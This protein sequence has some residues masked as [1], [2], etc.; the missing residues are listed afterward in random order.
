MFA[1][2]K[3][4]EQFLLKLLA[5]AW[6]VPLTALQIKEKT[7]A[8]G[9]IHLIDVDHFLQSLVSHKHRPVKF[10]EAQKA[11]SI[12]HDLFAEYIRRHEC[13]E[14][15]I[16]LA[17]LQRLIDSAPQ[18]YKMTATLLTARQLAKLW[19]YRETLRLEP[20]VVEVI[21]TSELEESAGD[22]RWTGL[23]MNSPAAET[24]SAVARALSRSGDEMECLLLAKLANDPD[25]TTRTISRRALKWVQAKWTWG[26]EW[27]H[28]ASGI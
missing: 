27:N 15:Q 1:D 28:E 24:R 10:N 9:K 25:S 16:E 17:V 26:D 8:A 4:E 20:M 7:E 2:F 23:L 11:F 13:N 3:P 6:P 21:V 19:Q 12:T 22:F 14:E 18:F 5:L